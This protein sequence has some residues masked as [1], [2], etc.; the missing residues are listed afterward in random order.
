[1]PSE[2]HPWFDPI[3]EVDPHKDTKSISTGSHVAPR[4]AVLTWV[5]APG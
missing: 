4:E 3:E 5:L 1:M 2:E